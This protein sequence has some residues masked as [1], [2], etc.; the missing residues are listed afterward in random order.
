MISIRLTAVFLMVFEPAVDA[1]HT[2]GR[3]DRHERAEQTT[4][5][6]WE[7]VLSRIEDIAVRDNCRLQGFQSLDQRYAVTHG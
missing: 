7:L 3:T 6:A 2:P 5:I 1:A 4:R